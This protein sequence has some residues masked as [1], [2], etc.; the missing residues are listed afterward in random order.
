[1]GD[2]ARPLNP[3]EPHADC[4]RVFDA[5]LADDLDWHEIRRAADEALIRPLRRPCGRIADEY[6]PLAAP[7]LA[8]WRLA[9]RS[10]NLGQ[11]VSFFGDDAVYDPG[12][13]VEPARGK[14]AIRR[15]LAELLH[16]CAISVEAAWVD[17]NGVKLDWVRRY[18]RLPGLSIR[19]SSLV[20]LQGT[21][22]DDIRSSV[23][24]LEDCFDLL[25]ETPTVEGIR[26]TET[27]VIFPSGLSVDRRRPS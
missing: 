3:L 1:V 8:D 24:R 17:C 11:I 13:G 12:T 6:L 5:I 16:E 22:F 14:A 4:Y 27:K 9:W 19:A 15:L 26:V 2:S 7:R 20:T 18:H 25:R 10:R 21:P 23:S